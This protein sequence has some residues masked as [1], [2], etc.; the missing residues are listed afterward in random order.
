MLTIYPLLNGVPPSDDDG[1]VDEDEGETDEQ[2]LHVAV[3][4]TVDAV[5]VTLIEKNF[6]TK[7]ILDIQG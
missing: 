1:D 6:K 7:V 3:H 5:V 2:C 4:G